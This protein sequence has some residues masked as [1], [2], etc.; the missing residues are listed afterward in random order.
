M[1]IKHLFGIPKINVSKIEFNAPNMQLF[2]SLIGKRAKCPICQKYSSSVHGR[3]QRTITDL[4]AFEFNVVIILSVR[5]FKCRNANCEQKVFT[6][7]HN[8]IASYAR[9]TERVDEILSNLAIEMTSGSGHKLSERMNMKVSRSTLIRL[10]HNQTLPKAKGLKVVGVDDWA[11]RKGINYGTILVDMETSKPIDLLPTRESEDL[12]LWLEKHPNIEIITRDRAS[13]YSSAIDEVCPQTIQVADRFHL[14][15]NLSD[16]LDTYFKSVSPTINTLIKNK[17]AELMEFNNDSKSVPT[18]VTKSQSKK[19]I[20]LE[21]HDSR[22]IVFEKVKALQ[23]QGY[24]RRKI[25]KDLGI[26]RNTVRSYFLQEQLTPKAHPLRTNIELFTDYIISQI[27]TEGH[28]IQQII[29]DIRKMGYYGG[30]TQAYQYITQLR[31]TTKGTAVNYSEHRSV[32]IPYIKRLSTRKLAKYIGRNMNRIDDPDERAYLKVLLENIPALKKV[33]KLVRKF[34][35]MLRKG[36]EEIED[37]IQVIKDSKVK[38]PGLITFARGLE[39]DIEAVKNGIKL[40]W[41]NGPVEGH[42][43][44]IKSIKRQMYGR[45]S[46]EMLRRKV[47]LSQYG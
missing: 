39:R 36:N 6:E 22:Q 42:V 34:K 21:R 16:A 30:N 43:N 35:T 26:S 33:R 11:F 7:R 15:M 28:I 3:Y 45:A 13:S 31:E 37:W 9:R 10:A 41:S 29:A 8:H 1:H 19:S 2:A 47:L 24:A 40:K 25:A 27:K 46:F 23:K 5:K 44:R 12:K 38:L 18:P 20:L 32:K 17:A 4:P 14:L